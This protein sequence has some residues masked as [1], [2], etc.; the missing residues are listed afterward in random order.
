MYGIGYQ[1]GIVEYSRDPKAKERELL[2]TL[3]AGMDATPSDVR[4]SKEGDF[5]RF[6]NIKH[7]QL[8]QISRVSTK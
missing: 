8:R 4:I 7:P 2:T 5:Y 1:Q 3:L 6:K